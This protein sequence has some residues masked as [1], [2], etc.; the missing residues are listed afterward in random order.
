MKFVLLNIKQRTYYK[1]S[2]MKNEQLN[3]DQVQS[4]NFFAQ[5]KLNNEFG[6]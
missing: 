1:P 3:F 6:K 2:R 5:L 4:F